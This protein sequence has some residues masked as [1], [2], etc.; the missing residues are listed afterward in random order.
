MSACNNVSLTP[1]ISGSSL[2]TKTS[3]SSSLLTM[4]LVLTNAVL[5]R[6]SE[7]GAVLTIFTV[8]TSF[9]SFLPYNDDGTGG[10]RKL[11]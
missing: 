11:Y 7:N 1:I 3:N 5:K 4:L 8:F 9:V 10:I 2:C 6:S